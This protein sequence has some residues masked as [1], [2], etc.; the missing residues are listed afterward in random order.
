VRIV[1]HRGGQHGW[2]TML[3]DIHQFADWFDE[4]LR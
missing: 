1:V 2:L 3:W 4:H